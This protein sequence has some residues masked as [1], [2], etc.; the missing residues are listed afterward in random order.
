MHGVDCKAVHVEAENAG[1]Y[2]LLAN[3]Y[4]SSGNWREAANLRL[5]MKDKGLKKQPPGCSWIEIAYRFHVFVVGD[6]SH[7]EI[8]LIYNL[9][10]DIHMKALLHNIQQ[11]Y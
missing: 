5:K 6:K 9:L 7:Y 1:T 2:M 11:D 8:K 4:S 10:G 3:I